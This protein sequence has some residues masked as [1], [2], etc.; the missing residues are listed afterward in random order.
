MLVKV[1]LMMIR[2]EGRW[3][4]DTER[5]LGRCSVDRSCT[6]ISKERSGN[7]TS[8]LC[9]TGVLHRSASIPCLRQTGPQLDPGPAFD[10]TKKAEQSGITMVVISQG[11]G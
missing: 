1:F 6:L 3:K 5:D 11:R 8:Y 10:H 2:S 9:R 7:R 4:T